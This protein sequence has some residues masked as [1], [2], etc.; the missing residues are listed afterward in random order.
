MR[1]RFLLTALL[2][3]AFA[4]GCG[5]ST[6]ATPGGKLTEAQKTARLALVQDNSKLNDVELIH[7]CPMLYPSDLQK[8]AAVDTSGKSEQ[9]K[10]AKKTLSKYRF[11]TQKIRVKSFTTAQLSSAK[12]ARCGNPI[13]LPPAQK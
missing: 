1:N 2:V 3:P 13:P 5:G 7:L 11:D 6:G 12:A 9:A 4:A 8:A 10:E